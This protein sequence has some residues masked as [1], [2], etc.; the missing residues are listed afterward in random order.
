VCPPSYNPAEFFIQKLSVIPGEE[1][2]SSQRVE[3]I[4]EAFS[5]LEQDQSLQLSMPHIQVAHN[6]ITR[7]R[8]IQRHICRCHIFFPSCIL[9]LR[10]ILFCGT[11]NDTIVHSVI[12]M[13]EYA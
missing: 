12:S 3:Q 1:E 6:S 11:Q 5:A 4:V 2:S 9:H 8:Y 13:R 10:F 7:V